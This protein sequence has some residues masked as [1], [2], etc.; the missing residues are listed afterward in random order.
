[1]AALRNYLSY[2]NP[3]WKIVFS[4]AGILL[5]ETSEEA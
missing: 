4:S 1:M 2:D 5:F 3:S